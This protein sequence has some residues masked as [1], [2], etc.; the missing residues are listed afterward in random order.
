MAALGRGRAHGH[1]VAAAEERFFN[2]R[3]KLGGGVAV[4]ARKVGPIHRGA[5]ACDR[6]L[7]EITFELQRRSRF[8]EA[9][10]R[11]LI[12]ETFSWSGVELMGDRRAASI[13]LCSEAIWRYVM[14][15]VLYLAVEKFRQYRPIASL[16]SEAL[17]HLVCEPRGLTI[18]W[19]GPA[20]VVAAPSSQWIACSAVRNGRGARPLN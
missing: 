20:I 19:S 4:S 12:G 17:L 7:R 11:R 9:L 14:T 5:V 8:T 6:L 18:R 10:Q 2:R 1:S 13:Y 16:P 3:H 15:K